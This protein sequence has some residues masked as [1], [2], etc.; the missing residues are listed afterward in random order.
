MSDSKAGETIQI[1]FDKKEWLSRNKYDIPAVHLD[2]FPRDALGARG[3]ADEGSYPF[4]GQS[5]EFDYGVTKSICDIATRKSGAMR[6]RDNTGMRKFLNA[7]EVVLGDVVIITR[8][9]SHRYKV[10][11]IKR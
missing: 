8:I 9:E 1:L 5:V 10:T 3:K 7:N 11:L 6:P 2:F 4:R